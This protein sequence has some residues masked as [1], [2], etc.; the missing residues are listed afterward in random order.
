MERWQGV[1]DAKDVAQLY[2]DK[3]GQWLLLEVIR[4]GK[5]GKAEKFKLVAYDYN[6]ERL[7]DLMEEDDWDWSKKYIFVFAD[8]DKL[9]EI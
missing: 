2:S 4:M 8:P 1:I 5:N 7:K 3:L 6:K 9:C